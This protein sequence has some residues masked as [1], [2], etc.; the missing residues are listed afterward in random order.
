[1][2][3]GAHDRTVR[4]TLTFPADIHFALRSLAKREGVTLGQVVEAAN[5][6]E[7]IRERKRAPKIETDFPQIKRRNDG[8]VVTTEYVRY[9]IEQ[10]DDEEMQRFLSPERLDG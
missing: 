7:I 10:M 6:E 4:T 5:R 1:M 2:G 9:L 8:T 3:F